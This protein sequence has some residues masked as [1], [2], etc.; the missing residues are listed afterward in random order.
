MGAAAAAQLLGD[1]DAAAQL[2]PEV[3]LRLAQDPGAELTQAQWSQLCTCAMNTLARAWDAPGATPTGGAQPAPTL[4]T[5]RALHLALQLAR[6]ALQR[7]QPQAALDVCM[8]ALAT[9][10]AAAAAPAAGSEGGGAYSAAD[11]DFGS[12]FDGEYWLGCD[13]SMPAEAGESGPPGDATQAADGKSALH[14]LARSQVPAAA[15]AAGGSQ[16]QVQP[17]LLD[18]AAKAVLQLLAGGD[19]SKPLEGAVEAAEA[20]WQLAPLIVQ[21]MAAAGAGKAAL[22]FT[23]RLCAALAA[24]D[25]ASSEGAARPSHVACVA[26][27]EALSA[28]GGLVDVLSMSAGDAWLARIGGALLAGPGMRQEQALV[29]LGCLVEEGGRAAPREVLL[30]LVAAVQ[31]QLRGVL[32]AAV[33]IITAPA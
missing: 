5:E 19:H 32:P 4:G 30:Q 2:P 9:A 33:R 18:C 31:G 23:E 11:D 21:S 15:A 16:P 28:V 27:C 3:L 25:S 1:A 6:A 14:M 13:Q 10:A 29:V 20:A 7:Q 26:V 22:L 24:A 17:Q 8:A 12:V